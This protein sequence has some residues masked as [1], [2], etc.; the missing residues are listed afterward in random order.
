MKWAAGLA[1]IYGEDRLKLV[2]AAYLVCGDADAS[3]DIVQDAFARAAE[4]W[5]AVE[6]GRAY[7]YTTVLNGARSF[8]R[9]A[10]RRHQFNLDEAVVGVSEQPDPWVLDLGRALSGLS[11]DQRQVIVMRYFLAWSDAQIGEAMHIRN[12]TVRSLLSR[13]RQRLRK[14]LEDSHE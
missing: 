9:R 11:Y 4:H 5:D 8:V 12:G 14:E 6:N 13:G 1:A 10:R 3:E 7:V 2:R